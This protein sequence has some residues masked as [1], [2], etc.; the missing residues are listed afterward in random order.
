MLEQLGRR[1]GGDHDGEASSTRES[2]E[3]GGSREIPLANSNSFLRYPGWTVARDPSP[4]LRGGGRNRAAFWEWPDAQPAK[5]QHRD[6]VEIERPARQLSLFA[7]APA[8]HV[9]RE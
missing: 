6:L 7:A 3:V 4:D 9:Y 5:V 2:A 8:D 1:L